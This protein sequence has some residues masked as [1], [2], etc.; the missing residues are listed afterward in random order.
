M[1]FLEVTSKF[2]TQNKYIKNLESLKWPKEAFCLYRA[3]S[4]SC[5]K[6]KENRYTCVSFKSSYSVNVG[7]I[8]ES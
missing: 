5:A 8:F 2:K 4:K 3:S 7:T 1:T 6:T